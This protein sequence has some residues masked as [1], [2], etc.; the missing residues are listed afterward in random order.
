MRIQ[1]LLFIFFVL[2]LASCEEK[3][4][5]ELD[6]V[7]ELLVVEGLITDA[8]EKAYVQLSRTQALS[9]KQVSAE[10]VSNA[11]LTI[12]DELGNVFPLEESKKE[13]GKYQTLSE[14]KGVPSVQ[15]RLNIALENGEVYQSDWDKMPQPIDIRKQ[16]MQKEQRKILEE[17]G[18]GGFFE[19]TLDGYEV[20]ASYYSTSGHNYYRID[21]SMVFQISKTWYF[22]GAPPLQAYCMY[23]VKG[24]R[25]AYVDVVDFSSFGEF[26]LNNHPISFWPERFYLFN[27][28]MDSVNDT[29]ASNIEVKHE[30]V[31]VQNLVYSL[32]ENAH[33]FWDAIQNQSSASG[34]LFDPMEANLP[35]NIHCTS[36][37]EKE[38][39]GF[40]GASALTVRQDFIYLDMNPHLTIELDTF[41]VIEIMQT[42]YSVWD[43]W[44][45]AFD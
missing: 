20:L 32:S 42:G 25:M 15:Y 10:K 34:K 21:Y 16:Q 18:Y 14:L 36:H 2:A 41:P 31:Q 38:V 27:F 24:R 40:F 45:N 43:E 23:P 30:G 26:Y 39:L 6:A 28:Q 37:P 8:Q 12:E 13:P 22:K 11:S 35:G 29:I 1:I 5:P 19:E 17:D 3:Y 33:G 44:I 9:S 7:D 4:S